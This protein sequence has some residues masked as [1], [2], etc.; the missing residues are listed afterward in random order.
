M[1]D[2][3]K[4]NRD[5][6][7][8][9]ENLKLQEE[10]DALRAENDSLLGRVDVLTTRLA[11]MA[12]RPD[13]EASAIH[14]DEVVVHLYDVLQQVAQ[15]VNNPLYELANTAINKTPEELIEQVKAKYINEGLEKAVRVC[16]SKAEQARDL[17]VEVTA[18]VAESLSEAI[19]K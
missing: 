10:I 7:T 17:E 11:D 8:Q 16:Q 3:L 9:R 1:V 19:A 12:E 6:R 14:G 18:I 15:D 5:K 2:T 13:D 4:K